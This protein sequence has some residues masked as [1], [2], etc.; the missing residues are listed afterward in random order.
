MGISRGIGTATTVAISVEV[1]PGWI[2]FV[3]GTN[4]CGDGVEGS[5][6]VFMTQYCGYWLRGIEHDPA[7]GW[8][9]FDCAA[10]DRYPTDDDEEVVAA[11]TAWR[12]GAPLPRGFIRMDRDFAL[13]A[14]AAGVRRGGARW[15]EDGDGI[16]YDCAVQCAAFGG[17]VLYG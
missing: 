15:Y 17:E 13:R 6:D 1:D 5:T 7:L 8:L 10:E 12:A 11:I 2:D 3:C 14:W 9:G 16:T 4:E